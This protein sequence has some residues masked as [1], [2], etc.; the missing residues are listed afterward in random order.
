[1][2]VVYGFC[3]NAQFFMKE[4]E[5]MVTYKKRILF[6]LFCVA[7]IAVSYSSSANARR[8]IA[9]A[10]LGRRKLPTLP[11]PM[12]LYKQLLLDLQHIISEEVTIP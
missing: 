8:V 11:I 1:M 12:S 4:V 7:M 5:K 9:Q 6:V 3:I 10:M 2:W